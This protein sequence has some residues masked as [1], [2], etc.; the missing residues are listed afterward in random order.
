MTL[1]SH[2]Q[3]LR[4]KFIEELLEDLLNNRPLLVE[5]NKTFNIM[6]DILDYLEKKCEEEYVANQ[7]M[8]RMCYLFR[9]F[10]VKVQKGVNFNEYKHRHANKIL[11]H[12]CV[13]YYKLCWDY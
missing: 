2:T 3:A 13:K 11:I 5:H 7:H 10:A 9:G 6:E 1:C 12:H 4:K 8:L